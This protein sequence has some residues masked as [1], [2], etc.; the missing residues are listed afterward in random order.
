MSGGG[1]NFNQ[2]RGNYNNYNQGAY[3]GN[4]NYYYNQ[5]FVPGYYYPQGAQQGYN[6]YGNQPIAYQPLQYQTQGSPALSRPNATPT[7]PKSGSSAL[8]TKSTTSSPSTASNDEAEKK[9]EEFKAALLKKAQERKAALAAAKT[10]STPATEPKKEEVVNTE[11]TKVEEPKVVEPK[12]EVPK[13]EEP[14]VEEPKVEE[15]KVEEPKAEEPKVEESKAEE[16]KVEEPKTEEPKAEESKAEESKAEEPKPVE[17]KPEVPKAEEQTFEAPKVDEIKQEIIEPEFSA[18]VPLYSDLVE[19]IQSFKLVEDPFSFDYEGKLNQPDAKLKESGPTLRYDPPF[20]LQFQK[21]CKFDA[22]DKFKGRLL[23][24]TKS[25]FE[26][27]AKGSNSKGFGQGPIGGGQFSKSSS[28]LRRL[29]SRSNSRQGSKRKGPNK[30]ERKSNRNRADREEREKEPEV[31][32]EPV[33]PLEKSANRW[34]PKSRLAKQEEVKYAPDGV[35]VILGEE[36]VKRKVKSFLNKLTL[37]FFD[38][39]TDSIIE[40]ANQSRWETDA[41]TLKAVID[42]VFDKAVDEPH[43]SS[44]YAQFCAKIFN[45]IHDEVKDEE[46]IKDGKPIE[47][48]ALVRRYLI[49]KC[50]VEYEKGWVDKLPTNEDG[51]AIEPELMSD[52]YYEI[53][54]AKRRGLGLVKFIGQLYVLSLLSENIIFA[55]LIK[56]SSNL[57]DPSDDTVENLIQ[58]FKT[59]GPTLDRSPND[60]TK[61]RFNTIVNRIAELA[62]NDK[63]PSRLQFSLLDVLDLRKQ[64]WSGG[65]QDKGPKTIQQIHE[66]ENKKVLEEQ[67]EKN[68][69][70]KQNRNTDSRQNSTRSQWGN[71][72]VSESDMLKVGHV[73]NPSFTSGPTNNFQKSKSARSRQFTTNNNTNSNTNNNNTNSQG[74]SPLTNNS[75]ND[76][77]ALSS[78]ENSKKPSESNRFAALLGDDEEEDHQEVSAEDVEESKEQETVAEE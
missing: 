60:R 39:I 49:T 56:Q 8:A 54:T 64:N 4:Q 34:I 41:K 43:W 74:S 66:E 5:G 50:Q 68:E 17:S 21:G 33:K 73:S 3:N 16:P 52:E 40:I 45:K 30:S 26:R 10:P 71:N 20:L 2:Q 25:I 65:E 27:P 19:K 57:D 76:L 42:L 35:T 51:S 6:T 28:N 58:L 62:T 37:E 18:N 24:I 70:R 78:R 9:R 12:V 29:D 69:K 53:A 48:K 55:C 75:T 31:P 72:R 77:Q 22:G 36:E 15:P 7:T 32:A 13:V 23:F 59:V 46:S 44:M 61:L 63:I 14:K 38:A 11:E 47:A 1:K 67:R